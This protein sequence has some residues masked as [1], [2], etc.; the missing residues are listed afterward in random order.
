MYIKKLKLGD[1]IGVIS[2]ASSENPEA[3][4]KGIIYIESLGFRVK[5]GK[6]IYAKLG[7]LAGSDKDRADDLMEMFKDK[8]VNAILCIRG[9]YG[10][11]RILPYLD[12]DIIKSNPKIFAGFSDI[13][14]LL[15][16]FH[17]KCDIIT[18]HSPMATSNLSDEATLKSFLDTLMNGSSYTIKNPDGIDSKA[19]VP[20]IAEGTL[21]GGNLCLI[22]ST[23]G[24]PYEIDTNNNILFLE[25][26]GE[27]PYK[28]DRMLT[29]LLLSGKL[30]S[31]S[32]F[33]LGQFKNCALPHYERSLTLDQVIEDRILKLNK[34]TLSNFMS[35]HDY[36]KLTLP[37]GAPAILD[38]YKKEIKILKAVV[39]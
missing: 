33:I 39:E 29:Q 21:V 20:G 24:T 19:L 28:I 4:E 23:I 10:T 32:G 37:I 17:Q 9:G 14:V 27:E 30:Q 15:N 35:G 36:P 1:T 2:P 25:E 26:V 31:C 34:P 5:R 3:I 38:V 11:M 22:A 7:Y 16:A 13:T 8:E 12:F 6:H 18:F